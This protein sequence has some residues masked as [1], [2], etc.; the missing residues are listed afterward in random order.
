MT[1]DHARANI[2]VGCYRLMTGLGWGGH[3]QSYEGIQMQKIEN[4]Q[5]THPLLP[6]VRS[7]EVW[8][9]DWPRVL[10]D[11]QLTGFSPLQC[12]MADPPNVWAT[13]ETGGDLQWSEKVKLQSGDTC[14]LVADTRLRMVSLDGKVKWTG[15]ATGKLHY[16]GDLRGDGKDTVLVGSGRDILLLDGE[17]GKLIWSHRFEPAYAQVRVAV[18]NV[19]PNRG[20]LEAVVFLAYAE[21]GCLISFG[22]NKAPEII[23][24]RMVVMSGDHPERYDHGCDVRLDLS[25]PDQPVIWNVRHHRCRGLDARTGETLSAL[26]YEIGEGHRRNYGPWELGQDTDGQP[27]ICVVGEDVQTHVHAIR[28][29]RNG[30]SELAWQHYYGELY[31]VP[32]VAVRCVK[33]G[34]VDGDGGT[35]VV[36]NVRDPQEGFRSFVRIRSAGD[37]AVKAELQDHWC[38]GHLGE[39]TFLVVPAPGGATPAGGNIGIWAA[40]SPGGIEKI[41]EV[42]DSRLWGPPQKVKSTFEFILQESKDRIGLVRYHLT[43]GAIVEGDRSGSEDLCAGPIK[44]V[45]GEEGPYLVESDGGVLAYSWEGSHLWS[46]DLQGGLDP[47]VSAADLNED[48]CAELVVAAAGNRVTSSSFGESGESTK[49]WT[50]DFHGAR[51]RMGPILYDLMGDGRLCLVSLGNNARGQI[52]VQAYKGDGE[53]LWET[54]LAIS[55][56]LNGVAMTWNAGTF[57]QGQRSGVAISVRND[58]RTVEGTYLLDG[59]NGEIVWYKGIYQE[60]KVA[61]PFVPHGIPSAYDFDGDGLDEVFIDMLSYMAVLKGEDGSFAFHRHTRNLGKQDALYAGDL[62]NSFVPLFKEDDN[63]PHWFV[64]LGGYGSFGL[65]KPDPREGV[66]MEDP[67][68]DVPIKVGM[69]DV[70]GD[71]EMEVG[72]CIRNSKVFVCRDLWTGETKWEI[73]LP[74]APGNPVISADVDGDGKGEFLTG[75]YCIGTDERGLGVIRWKSPV[76]FGWAVI[77]DFD[78]DGLGEIACV[79]SGRIYVLKGSG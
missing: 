12:G 61:R 9:K 64:P 14:L 65:M 31:V 25:V 10:H 37:G 36:Y 19:L 20:G 47:V 38:L 1:T 15:E 54:E 76:E 48:G 35:E 60:G 28:L 71:G 45:L 56:A 4:K 2:G 23:W 29:N 44:E 78:G 39:S 68:Y 30:P 21:D 42:Q 7:G 32:G 69:I 8:N 6:G 70:D 5:H 43:D 13:V 49:L 72:Y 74:E 75:R 51:S 40:D 67:G 24:E 59:A 50:K 27:M 79:D 55:T 62:Y 34:D 66:W 16:F 18:G 17:N 3:A 58:P 41:G 46:L 52:T 33:I 57:L 11:K 22:E 26:V 77:A 73:E 53:K 63:L